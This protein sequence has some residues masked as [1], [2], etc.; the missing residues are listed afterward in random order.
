MPELNFN[1][2][3]TFFKK[4]KLQKYILSETLFI[5]ISLMLKQD[6]YHKPPST[7]RQ[8]ATETSFQFLNC[9]EVY[10]I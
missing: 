5:N 10:L 6:I 1:N 2:S 4:L 3:L 9:Y 7:S 8:M